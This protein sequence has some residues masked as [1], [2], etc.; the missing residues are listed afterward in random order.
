MLLTKHPTFFRA[1]EAAASAAATS[2]SP[3][4]AAQASD[5][6]TPG[7]WRRRWRWCCGRCGIEAPY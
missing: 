7:G 1:P 3:K 5:T 6:A 2:T 4:H